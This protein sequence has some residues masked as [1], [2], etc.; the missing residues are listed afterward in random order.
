MTLSSLSPLCASLAVTGVLALLPASTA[1]A[2][3]RPIR[4]ELVT[5]GL[6]GPVLVTAPQGDRDRIFVV[7]QNG[8]V[9]VSVNGVPQ[10]T[11]YADLTAL[12]QRSGERGLL[13]MAFDPDYA[14]NGDVFFS[15]TNLSGNTRIDRYTVDAAN[16]NIVDDSTQLNILAQNQPFSNHNGGMITFGPDGY[17]YVGLGDGGLAGDPG[18]RAQNRNNLLGKMLRLDVSN[19]AYTIP[20]DN[21]FVGD[22]ST[23]DEIW[24]IGLRNPWRFS[25]DRATGDMWIADVGQNVIEEIDFEPAGMGGLNYGWR[26]MEGTDCYNP[27]NNCNQTGL[28]LPI[29]EYTHGGSPFRC[30]ITGGYV[31]RGEAMA[32]MHG[33]YFYADYCSEQVWSFRR[34]AA[35]LVE[36]FQEHTAELGGVGSVTG[37]GQDA[38]G[39]LYI[40]NESGDV[41][42]IVADGLR[43]QVSDAISGGT[44]E[45]RVD[46]G[47]PSTAAYL[48]FSL[49]GVGSTSVPQLNVTLDLAAPQLLSTVPTDSNGELIAAGFVPSSL[50]GI[51]V[52]AQAA[53][54]GEVSNV[55]NQI[56]Q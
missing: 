8:I 39:E 46:G 36:D 16:P 11:P 21:P 33:R 52:W 40:C 37:F 55:V 44:A 19:G 5:S 2:A 25:F 56:V 7:Q 4:A 31:Y 28:E 23:A 48:I 34:S 42:R 14:T 20:A 26:I 51:A 47:A 50:S 24:S 49:A 41:Y 15:Y 29:F 32:T 30:S 38:R 45:F 35:G 13:G 17:L 9:A 22:A 27:S 3:Q 53:Q 10:A 1:Q 12:T 54:T 6:S 43:L 18:N